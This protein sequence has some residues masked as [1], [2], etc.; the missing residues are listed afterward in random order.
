MPRSQKANRRVVD[1]GQRREAR[2]GLW[3]QLAKAVT[4][5]ALGLGLLAG[6]GL[7]VVQGRAYALSSPR[8]ALSTLHFEG[9][10]HASQADLARLSGLTPGQNLFTADLS[11]VQRLLETH[12]WVQHVEVMRQLP[13]TVHVLVNEHVPVAMVTLGDLY[14]LDSQGHAFKKVEAK[15]LVDLPLL[16]GV[17]REAYVK[18]PAKTAEHFREALALAHAYDVSGAGQYGRL[19]EVRRVADGLTLVTDAGQEIRFPTGAPEESLQ[20]LFKVRSELARRGLVAQVIHLDNR[21]RPDRITVKIFDP[22]LRD[23]TKGRAGK[24]A[25]LRE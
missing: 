23:E 13:D 19:S 16:T 6:V 24:S 9:L 22:S 14:L 10:Q 5:A 15:D 4:R 3:R 12:P 17:D 8:F 21:V 7:A 1:P 25:S 11:T 20:R 2:L 18:D